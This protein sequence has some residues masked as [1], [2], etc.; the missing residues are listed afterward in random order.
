MARDRSAAGALAL[1]GLAL[2]EQLGDGDGDVAC[3]VLAWFIGTACEHA[4]ENGTT[5][6]DAS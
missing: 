6:L 2:S 3:D 5:E 1:I 4:N